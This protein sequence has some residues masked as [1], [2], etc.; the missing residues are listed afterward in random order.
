MQHNTAAEIDQ[1]LDPVQT[2]T[3][4]KRRKEYL[5]TTKP[6]KYVTIGVC[7]IKKKKPEMIENTTKFTRS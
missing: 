1:A 3:K 7:L 4:E 5:K 2:C 6:K